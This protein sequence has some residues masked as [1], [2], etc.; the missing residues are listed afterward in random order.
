M[1]FNSLQF[2]LFFPT[3]AFVH[4]ALPPRYRW[5]W[6]LA[7]SYFFYMCWEPGYAAL[8]LI[9]TLVDYAA[10]ILLGRT[11]RQATRR[12][13]LFF[14]LAANL[15]LLF[16][17]KYY[18]FF[19]DSIRTAL[20][21]LGFECALPLSGF[22]LPVGI[23]FYTF[24][25]LSYTI[26]VYRGNQEPERHLGRFALYV[27]FFPQLVA[28]PI[29]RAPRLLPQLRRWPSFDYD[30]VTDGLKLIFWGLFK[31]VVIADRLASFVTPIYQSPSAHSGLA[32]ST[33]TLFFAFQIYCDFSGYTDIAIGAA[34][35]F[36]VDL[37]DNFKRP[38]AARSIR[39]F[40]RRWHISLSTWFR[41][42]VYIPLGGSHVTL[43]RWQVNILVVF[44]LS[45]LWH[46]ANW[47][48]LAWGLLH[49]GYLLAGHTIEPVR[50]RLAAAVHLDRH[51]RLL[52]IIQ[53]LS[54]FGLVCFAWIFF[55]ANTLSDAV[56]VA[57]H[58]YRDWN[59]PQTFHAFIN[60][61]PTINME[62]YFFLKEFGLSIGLIGFLTI[63]QAFQAREPIRV[64]MH[65]WPL[66]LRFGV[67]S[68][69]LWFMFLFG[70]FRQQ[71]FIYFTF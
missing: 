19:A 20:E 42:Y 18:N 3:V 37:M 17:F 33:A 35:V 65:R 24:Q 49:G 14:S 61:G 58:W 4:F 16:F 50:A 15:G 40:W 7:A 30:R 48:F 63:V 9:S 2:V 38:Y 70:V 46:G 5:A 43:R 44:F 29:E 28:G 68:L 60:M 54:T 8:I 36:G 53:T 23:S 31:K 57:T 59:W 6:Q 56:Y 51:D 27:A 10:G 67:Y 13:C 45:G 66:W 32:L 64:R 69:G 22:L 47:T 41:D 25:T 62:P 39:D 55:R 52:Q 71:E 11:T 34:R 12:G 26:E 21:D 1:L